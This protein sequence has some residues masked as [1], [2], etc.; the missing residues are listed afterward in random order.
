MRHR[1]T[2]R[3]VAA[4]AMFALI[5]AACGT[6]VPDGTVAAGQSVSN[7]GAV[8][9]DGGVPA[10]DD[11]SLGTTPDGGGA[12]VVDSSGDAGA[13][14]SPSA[15]GDS[16]GG[17]ESADSGGDAAEAGQAAATGPLSQGVTDDEILIGG[18]GPLSGVTGFLGE[19]VFG[20]I[21]S[22][23]Q[24][25][26]SRGGING[27][28]LRLIS[29]DDRFDSSQT[30]ANTRRLWEQDKVAAIF[31]AFGDPVADYATRN[32]IPTIVFG[33]TP[34][35]FSS[36]YPTIYPI[37]GNALIWT[38]EVIR[39]LK[40][41][42]VFKQGMKVGM[43][44]DTQIL[45]VGPYVPFLKAAWEDAGAEVVSTDP[46]N[47]TDGD[48]TN[49]VLKM[50]DLEIDYWDFQGLGWILCASA[51]Q[52]QQY[53]PPV[54][55]GNWPTSVGGL[56]TQVGPWVDGIWGGSQGDQPDGSPRQKTAAHD[57]YVN[58]IKRY[59]PEI[60]SFSHYDSPA[61]IGYWSGAQL[62][63][64]AIEAQGANITTEG[65]LDWIAKV[66]NFE[67]GITPPI[68]SMAPNCKTGSE[69]VWI[70]QWKWDS[71]KKEATRTPATGYFTSDQKEKY[72][73]KCFLTKVSD[74]LG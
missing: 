52:R 16:G 67:T 18:T 51:A 70:G 20:A 56:A 37:V 74:Q 30:L 66:E 22:Y 39:G 26:N 53:R 21:D 71:A 41:Q 13:A 60:A 55:W 10:I 4:G 19:E 58:S 33:V 12:A 9:S 63:V 65:V 6:R 68:I 44:Y 48:C 5:V 61:T 38:Q 14:S 72:G 25:V 29:Y 64:A 49:L 24:L 36:K 23:F 1:S 15:G 62:I 43:M 42:G 11:S 32:R 59:H 46:F 28:K 47:L 54:G 2:I 31:L 45:D 69:V 17:G 7:G 35:S 50:K 40:E 27:R 3:L 8:T 73:G 57:E 34:K